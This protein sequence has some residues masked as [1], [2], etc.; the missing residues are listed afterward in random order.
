MSLIKLHL[1]LSFVSLAPFVL[2]YVVVD[3]ECV[4]ISLFCFQ[5]KKSF[6]QNSQLDA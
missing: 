1:N 6:D 4:W 3:L 2:I 5:E